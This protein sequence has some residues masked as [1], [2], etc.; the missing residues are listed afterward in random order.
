MAEKGEL[1]RHGEDWA[2]NME[3]DSFLNMALYLVKDI[4]G[5]VF[6][7]GMVSDSLSA[8]QDFGS[9]TFRHSVRVS[10]LSMLCGISLD[11]NREQLK[12]LCTGALLHDLGKVH[13]AKD[14]LDKPDKLSR[15]E[16]EHVKKHSRLGFDILKEK[17]FSDAVS[18]VALQ[19]HERFDGSG[20]PLGLA[21]QQINRLASV[22]AVADTFEALTGD[23]VYRKSYPVSEAI[24][25]IKSLS[26]TKLDPQVS[27]MFLSALGDTPLMSYYILRKELGSAVI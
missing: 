8:I 3:I 13:L 18:T 9:Q 20:Y 21:N 19:H 15:H 12:D 11:F 25:A 7:D 1:Q 16:Y 23:R 14:V 6:K 22:V 2:D 27:M 24:E 5:S 4:L 10:V 26:G 17:G